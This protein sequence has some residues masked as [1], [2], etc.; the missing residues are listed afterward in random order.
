MDSRIE[1][2]DN[3][4]QVSVAVHTLEGTDAIY[5]DLG[6]IESWVCVNLINTGWEKSV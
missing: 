3:T 6:R 1:C 4:T 2:V 5:R